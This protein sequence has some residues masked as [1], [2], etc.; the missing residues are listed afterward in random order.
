MPRMEI[1]DPTVKVSL[2]LEGSGL[3]LVV[4]TGIAVA[5]LVKPHDCRVVTPMSTERALV[6]MRLTTYMTLKRHRGIRFIGP[7]NVDQQRYNSFVSRLSAA[8]TG[9]QA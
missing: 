5:D 3:F 6:L 4:T 2:R 9:A 7:V 1:S 8:P